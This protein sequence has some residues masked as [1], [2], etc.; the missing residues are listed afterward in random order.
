MRYL[1]RIANVAIIVAV[2][3]FLVMVF[4]GEIGW[5]KAPPYPGVSSATLVGTAV[6]L[7]S[8][9]LPRDRSSLLIVVSTECHFC[10]DSLPFYRELTAR[11]RGKVQVVAVLPQAQPE[12]RKF[13]GDAGI[14]ADRIVTATPETLGVRGTP[15]VLLVDGSGKV[16][17]VW[18]GQ[19]DEAGQKNLLA[20][21]LPAIAH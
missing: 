21:A 13:L 5:R 17:Q 1:D 14:E 18:E 9:D 19:L 11:T 20:A 8:V 2:V 15:T 3:V 6:K 12:A 7:P 4:R 16:K 10:R